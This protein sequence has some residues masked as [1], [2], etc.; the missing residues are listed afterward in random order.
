MEFVKQTIDKQKNRY[1]EELI[2]LLKIPSVSADPNYKDACFATADAV[3]EKMKS[4]GLEKVEIMATPGFP[5]VYGE[6]IIDKNL[7]TI[8]VY[9]HYDV[10]PADPLNLW[11]SPPFEPIIKDGKIYARGACDD[12]GQMFMHVKAIELMIQNSALP[13]NVKMIV[14]GEEEVGSDNLGDFIAKYK[15][16]LACDVVLVSDTSIIS[17][18]VPSVTVGLRG[19]CYMEV[20]VTGPNRDL[21][22]GVYGG[23]V[24]NPINAL[25]EMIAKMKDE[26]DHIT[27]DHFYDDVV[28]LSF[29]ERTA[30]NEAPFSL[31]DY[32][33]DLKLADVR[34]EKGYTS[35]ERTSI[36]PTIDV[37]GIWGGYIG[38]GAKTVLPSK[39]FAKIS[40]RLV[41]NQSSDKIAQLFEEYFIK[42]APPS[43]HVSVKTHHGGEPVVT[44]TDSVAYKAAEKAMETTFGKKPIPQRGG[45][46]IPI[47]ALFEA[48]LNAKTVLMGFGLDSD[49]IH[50]PNEHYGIFNFLKGIE[51][52]PYF[53]KYYAE[54]F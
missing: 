10:Q 33:R 1:I 45:G 39:A 31:E 36:R 26:N 18:D 6:K 53:Y 3:A 11:H 13:C 35:L 49:D 54:L 42:I 16:K 12:K 46:S 32:K 24:P 20:E 14:E 48:E 2:E 52:I 8:L 47:V 28:E 9:G 38:E 27:I 34:G 40:M 25:C 37:N 5:V 23:A 44:P 43:I 4:A 51:T 41:P 21:H 7:P 19:L 30:M 17:N 29:E 22:S 50:S 15:E